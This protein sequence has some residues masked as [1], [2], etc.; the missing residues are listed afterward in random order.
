MKP[1]NNVIVSAT[2]PKNKADVWIQHSKNL[3]DENTWIVGKS[4]TSTGQEYSNSAWSSSDYIP[5]KE[6]MPVCFSYETIGNGELAISE[7]D[8]NKTFLKQTYKSFSSNY[9]NKI[10]INTMSNTKFVRLSSRN[11]RGNE[12]FMLEYGTTRSSYEP[13][14][15][16]DILV[17]D[18][19]TYT[20]LLQI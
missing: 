13:Y 5:I 11:D 7:Y 14:A 15:E 17:N 9:N 4:I 19:G 18:N 10:V 16:D 1:F 6:A 2:E 3:F 20:S 12:D 8:V